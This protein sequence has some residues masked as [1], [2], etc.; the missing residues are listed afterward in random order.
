MP[1]AKKAP[2]SAIP[3]IIKNFNNNQ[4]ARKDYSE[5]NKTD[6]IVTP[7]LGVDKNSIDILRKYIKMLTYDKEYR[8]R[9]NKDFQ[10]M[11]GTIK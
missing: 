4:I 5:N 7:H 8:L 6:G 1:I 9:V 3:I 11:M 10:L 2:T